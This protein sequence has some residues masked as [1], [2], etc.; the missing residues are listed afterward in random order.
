M[1]KR[2]N[3]EIVKPRKIDSIEASWILRLLAFFF[4]SRRRHTRWNCDWSS[5][6]ALPILLRPHVDEMDV[7]TVDLGE[8][9]RQ[10]LEPRLALAPVVV[11]GPVAR[12]LLGGRKADPLR[13]VADRFSLGQIGRASCRERE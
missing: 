7:E 11:A 9:V 1:W 6:C 5:E 13:V 10:R 12:Q 3:T 4:S 8:E 2:N